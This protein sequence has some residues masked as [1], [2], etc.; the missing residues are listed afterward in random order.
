MSSSWYRARF[1]LTHRLRNSK[2]DEY[3]PVRYGYLQ[4]LHKYLLR[5][6]HAPRWYILPFLVAHDV[7]QDVKDIVSTG[8]PNSVIARNL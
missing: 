7:E 4:K 5:R 8:A 2:Q 1:L 3:Y 6:K